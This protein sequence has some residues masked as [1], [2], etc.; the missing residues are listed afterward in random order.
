MLHHIMCGNLNRINPSTIYPRRMSAFRIDVCIH[1]RD[2]CPSDDHFAV[3]RMDSQ[4]YLGRVN[5]LSIEILKS[6]VTYK[7]CTSRKKSVN[8]KMLSVTFLNLYRELEVLR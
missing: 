7:C 2:L 5:L 1:T 6:G 8:R 3:L 4:S